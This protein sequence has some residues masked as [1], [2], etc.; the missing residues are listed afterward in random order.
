MTDIDDANLAALTPENFQKLEK[1]KR[2]WESMQSAMEKMEGKNK[3]EGE[4]R[5]RQY[6]DKEAEIRGLLLELGIEVG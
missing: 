2:E 6:Q 5:I 4:G 3:Y 1:L